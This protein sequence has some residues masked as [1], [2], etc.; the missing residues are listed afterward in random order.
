MIQKKRFWSLVSLA[1]LCYSLKQHCIFQASIEIVSL[2]QGHLFSDYMDAWIKRSCSALTER[3]Y[4][5]MRSEALL[6]I[7]FWSMYNCV[8]FA[9]FIPGFLFLKNLPKAFISRTEIAQNIKNWILERYNWQIHPC[10]LRNY[11]IQWSV[12]VSMF[13]AVAVIPWMFM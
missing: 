10:V 5:P 1:T 13:R 11:C 8:K 7:H 3:C 9:T 6:S 4:N 2:K 12:I